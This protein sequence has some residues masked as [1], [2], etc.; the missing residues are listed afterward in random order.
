MEA[1]SGQPKVQQVEVEHLDPWVVGEPFP[2]SRKPVR[3]QLDGQHPGAGCGQWC[4]QRTV[5]GTEVENKITRTQSGG[6]DQLFGPVR[7]QPVPSP[8]ALRWRGRRAPYVRTRSSPY[9]G[10]DAPGSCT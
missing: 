8:E 10:H 2:Q 4:G 7:L 1:S 6:R 9:P 3:M 5:P